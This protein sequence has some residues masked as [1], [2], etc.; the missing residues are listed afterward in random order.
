MGYKLIS[1]NDRG[2]RDSQDSL[3]I[4]DHIYELLIKKFYRRRREIIAIFAILPQK[5]ISYLQVD[6]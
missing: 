5:I 1:Y 6:K 4:L 3:N 2:S